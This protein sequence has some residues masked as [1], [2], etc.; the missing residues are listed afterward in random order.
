MLEFGAKSLCYDPDRSAA[1]FG[2][3][4]VDYIF[5]NGNDPTPL[6]T[7]QANVPLDPTNPNSPTVPI[8]IALAVRELHR[9]YL[10]LGVGR[11][12]YVGGGSPESWRYFAGFEG[13][14]RLGH[15]HVK[16][17]STPTIP[18]N[19]ALRETDFIQNVFLGLHAGVLIPR[20]GYDIMLGGRC[21]WSHDWITIL[22]ADHDIDQIQFLLTAGVRY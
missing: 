2:T 18:S 8:T 17:Y 11:E 1:W 5:N 16:F 6:G 13:G 14:G 9:T 10:H 21:E 12:W 19:P 15:A 22:E 7:R 20:C 4:G 3:I